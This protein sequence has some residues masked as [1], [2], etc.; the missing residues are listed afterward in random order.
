MASQVAKIN[1]EDGQR[2]SARAL[3]V[4]A[5]ILALLSATTSLLNFRSWRSG[6]HYSSMAIEWISSGRAAVHSSQVLAGIPGCGFRCRPWRQ[7]DL[8]T[9]FFVAIYLAACNM[10]EAYLASSLLYRTIAPRPDLTE[11]KQL[12]QFLIYGVVVAPSCGL[13]AGDDVIWK[14]G[15]ARHPP[16][17]ILSMVVY[18]RC[19]GHSGSDSAL[20]FVCAAEAISG[21]VV[22][23]DIRHLCRALCDGGWGVLANARAAS[24][25]PAALPSDDRHSPGDWLVQRSVCWPCRS[26]AGFTRLRDADLLRLCSVRR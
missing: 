12:I 20:P 4:L 11:R 1:E 6:R 3:I 10:L 14:A 2:P 9:P 16:L 23:G 7:P 22:V 13:G 17:A 5:M 21:Q 25:R 24:L 26:L 18:G 15:Q 19:A 8:A